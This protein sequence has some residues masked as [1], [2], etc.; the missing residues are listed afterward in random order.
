MGISMPEWL[1]KTLNCVAEFTYW[2]IPSKRYT[3]KW[4]AAE[5]PK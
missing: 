3:R 1:R 5:S 4:Y 2:R